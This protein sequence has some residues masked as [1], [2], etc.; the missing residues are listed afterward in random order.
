MKRIYENSLATEKYRALTDDLSQ[1]PFSFVY[2]GKTY[3]G[4]SAEHFDLISK[5]TVQEGEKETQTFRLAFLQVLEVTLIL[6]HYFSH[7]VTEWTV[8]F[9]NVSNKNSGVIEQIKTEL[10]FEGKYPLLKAF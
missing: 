1:L 5:D 2:D 10:T 9:E 7:G 4:F 6:T 8:W 3:K